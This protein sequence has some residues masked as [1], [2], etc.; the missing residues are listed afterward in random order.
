MADRG[1]P[2]A[3]AFGDGDVPARRLRLLHRVFEPLMEP[4][5]RS[6]C[7]GRRGPVRLAVDLGCGPGHTTRDLHR[8]TGADR[9]FGLDLSP[10]FVSRAG[11]GAPSAISFAVADVTRGGLPGPAD[12]VYARYLLAHLADPVAAV[13]H[14]RGGLAGGGVL[15]LEEV[16]TIDTDD[17]I[18]ARYLEVAAGLLASRGT[19]L[20]VGD[21]LDAGDTIVD[22]RASIS[23][24]AGLAAELF[25][26]NLGVWRD[27]PW[28]T[29]H[30]RAAELDDLAREIDERT[31]WADTGVITWT[32]RQVALAATPRELAGAQSATG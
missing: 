8:L 16:A 29:A 22:R 24:P 27:D 23:P 15:L 17:A 12:V 2:P 20:Y 32:H 6:V 14:W 31:D 4:F 3:Y 7:D 30:V 9:T 11:Q 28:V 18:F 13:D 25:A 19:D 1:G 26:L 10:D 21:R 5:V